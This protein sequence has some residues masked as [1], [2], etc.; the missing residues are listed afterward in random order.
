MGEN[1]R[2]FI[3]AKTARR[4]CLRQAVVLLINEILFLNMCFRDEG[5][6]VL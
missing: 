5:A 2:A 4:N 1:N 6:G 3:I